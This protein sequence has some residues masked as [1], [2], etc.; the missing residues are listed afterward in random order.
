MN[1][2]ISS[3]FGSSFC[4]QSIVIVEQP[5][6][7]VFS[8]FIC[9]R[10]FSIQLFITNHVLFLLFVIL[11]SFGHVCFVC[12]HF[13][14][15]FWIVW[16]Y[17]HLHHMNMSILNFNQFFK[18]L[19]HYQRWTFVE[20]SLANDGRHE[21]SRAIGGAPGKVMTIVELHWSVSTGTFKPR[22]QTSSV[23]SQLRVNVAL[24]ASQPFVE[25]FSASPWI[26]DSSWR[27]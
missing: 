12:S 16:F 1:D 24:K 25:K 4:S 7:T 23:S 8:A 22:F 26:F 5:S 19:F 6:S 15:C 10:Y 21:I 17:Y 18:S 9:L 14:S 11:S 3:F 20:P 2:C 13:L 27:K